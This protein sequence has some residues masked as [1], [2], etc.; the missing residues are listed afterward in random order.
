[1]EPV[2]RF[3]KAVSVFGNRSRSTVTQRILRVSIC[4]FF[5]DED[6]FRRRLYMYRIAI[7]RSNN[8]VEKREQSVSTPKL[9][10]AIFSV[11]T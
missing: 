8:T 11:S 3:L 6:G 9:N 5:R 1:M 7:N 4:H 2:T 10:L